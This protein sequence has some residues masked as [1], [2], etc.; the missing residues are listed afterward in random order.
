MGIDNIVFDFA[1]YVE[2]TNKAF[3]K[4]NKARRRV[5]LAKDA[6]LRLKEKNIIASNNS[7]IINLPRYSSPG[8]MYKSFKQTVNTSN[9]CMVCAKGALLV[10][11][12]GRFNG[13]EN[14]EL[15]FNNTKNTHRELQKYFTLEQLDMIETAFEGRSLMRKLSEKHDQ[16]ICQEIYKKCVEFHDSYSDND[17]RLNAIFENIVKNKGEFIP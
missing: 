8:Y 13:Y 16:E 9:E 4:S 15:N 1:E 2:K 5:L 17:D 14:Y 12:V 10:S 11:A 6:L 3:M 7:Y